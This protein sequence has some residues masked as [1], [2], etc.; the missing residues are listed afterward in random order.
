MSASDTA[1]KLGTVR[2]EIDSIDRQMLELISA[3]ARCALRVAEIKSGST[4]PEEQEHDDFYRPAREAQIL[5]L[6]QETNPGPLSGETVARLF[7]EIISACLA[8]EGPL[9]VA[10]LGPAGTFTEAAAYKHFGHFVDTK[11][12]AAIDEV[13]REVDSGAANYGV[14]PIENSTEGVINHTLD[15][16]LHSS[17]KICGEVSLRVHHQLLSRCKNKAD[18]QAIYAHGQA[19]AQCRK[20]LDM[21]M[22]GVERIAVGSNAEG[23]IRAADKDNCAAIASEGAGHIYG[24][25]IVASNIEDEPDN[26]TRFLVIG[27]QVVPQSGDKLGSDMTSIVAAAPNKAGMLQDLIEPF[28]TH[29]VSM[30]R[31]ESRPSRKEAWD[32]VFFID[33]QGHVDDPKVRTALE[34]VKDSATL[35]K[36]LGSYPA[37]VL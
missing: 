28:S 8:L 17:L 13:F 26:T 4:D 18:I 7:R 2:D 34:S 29:G 11:P 32:Y 20:W 5:R 21:N 31:I 3:R 27:R 6:V 9:K 23:A 25:T 14:V 33:I 19:L 15:E 37:A 12:Q 36:V 1:V 10:Y 35:F 30:T 24:L 22:P 16:F